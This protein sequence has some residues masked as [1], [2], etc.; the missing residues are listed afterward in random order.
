MRNDYP[1]TGPTAPTPVTDYPGPFVVLPSTG[2]YLHGIATLDGLASDVIGISSLKFEITGGG[3]T[4]DVVATGSPTIYGY[5][6]SWNTSSVSDGTYALQAVACN[7]AGNCSV[8]QG[9]TVKPDNTPPTTSVGIPSPG[10]S[11]SGSSV[12]SMPQQVTPGDSS[13]QVFSLS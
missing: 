5:V 12:S 7:S 2:S 3:L 4:N 8:S 10:A 11:V 9:I 1:S 6:A 13:W